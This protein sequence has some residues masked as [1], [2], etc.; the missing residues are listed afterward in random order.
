MNLVLIDNLT[1]ALDV[2]LNGR[3]LFSYVYH[4][5]ALREEGPKPYFHPLRTLGG[6]TV[7]L[8]R[9]HDHPWHCGLSMTCT[10]VSGDNFWGGYSW[11]AGHGYKR[12]PNYGIQRHLGWQSVQC[13]DDHI[14]IAEN[15]AWE[16]IRDEVVLAET[17]EIEV[18]VPQ[19]EADFWVLQLGFSLKN[20]SGR[21]LVFSSPTVEGRPMAGYGGL[22]WRGPRSF[23]DGVVLA[24]DNRVGPELMSQRS[25]WLAY[26]GRHD[27]SLAYSTVIIADRPNN[28]RYPTQWFVRNTPFACA[29]AAF[30]FDEAYTLPAEE[31]LSLQYC[32]FIADG[33]WDTDRIENT[34]RLLHLNE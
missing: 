27:H 16:S 11:V 9:P 17:R 8:L 10:S 24:S 14:H 18:F 20:V 1:D 33:A 25:P 22:F 4:S 5:K 23:N 29:S 31:T 2:S 6:E 15:I 26:V 21:D 34:L 19:P 30:M 3:S 28:V 12:V 32:V 13:E 7:T